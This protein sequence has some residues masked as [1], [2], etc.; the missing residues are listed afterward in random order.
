MTS[1][2]SDDEDGGG[3]GGS[4]PLIIDIEANDTPV[5][6]PGPDVSL[7]VQLRLLPSTNGVANQHI[8]LPTPTGS[9]QRVSA[10]VGVNLENPTGNEWPGESVCTP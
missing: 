4:G 6:V 2:A 3:E 8:I 5:E 1:W 10:A 7:D 9:G